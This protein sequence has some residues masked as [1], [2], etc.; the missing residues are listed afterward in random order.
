MA[1]TTTGSPDAAVLMRDYCDDARFIDRGACHSAP[2]H[3]ADPC[4]R[5]DADGDHGQSQVGLEALFQVNL[6][7]THNAAFSAPASATSRMR[8]KVNIAL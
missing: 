4:A 6:R 7:L 2:D 8:R 1:E 3:K 5:Y